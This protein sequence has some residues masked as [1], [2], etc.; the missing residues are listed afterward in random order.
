MNIQARLRPLRMPVMIGGIAAGNST[1]LASA[2][3]DRPA[4]R[5][6]STSLRS[7]SRKP[8]DTPR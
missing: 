5:A 8:D 4:M 7:T 1:R 6:T 3:C 2:A